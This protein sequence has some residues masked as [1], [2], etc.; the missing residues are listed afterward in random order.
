MPLKAMICAFLLTA[1]IFGACCLLMFCFGPGL[2][3]PM[4]IYPL[5]LAWGLS[6][7]AWPAFLVLAVRKA[8][9]RGGR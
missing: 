9:R 1:V 7:V 3:D 4:W 8:I 2:N 5:M 6:A